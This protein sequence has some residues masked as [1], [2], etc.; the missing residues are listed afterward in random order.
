MFDGCT[1]LKNLKLPEGYNMKDYIEVSN[2]VNKFDATEEENLDIS[3]TKNIEEGQISKSGKFSNKIWKIPTKE[4]NDQIPLNNLKEEQF[5][6]NN[7]S[8]VIKIEDANISYINKNKENHRIISNDNNNSKDEYVSVYNKMEDEQISKNG[9]N[10]NKIIISNNN[11]G[12]YNQNKI[13]ISQESNNKKDN[14]KKK[15]TSEQKGN[16]ENNQDGCDFCAYC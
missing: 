14:E 15:E 10:L 1:S 13:T 2:D 8:K 6:N 4:S 7:P 16:Y 3:K 9:E 11:D 5:N 12:L